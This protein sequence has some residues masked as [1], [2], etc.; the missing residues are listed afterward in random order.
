MVSVVQIGRIFMDKRTAAWTVRGIA[1]H[2]AGA[3]D[4]SGFNGL[5]RYSK[6][7]ETIDP[8]DL[9][10]ITGYI[11]NRQYGGVPTTSDPYAQGNLTL[12]KVVEAGVG[13]NTSRLEG[14]ITSSGNIS[15]VDLLKRGRKILQRIPKLGSY[16]SAQL[17]RLIAFL[18]KGGM[19]KVEFSGNLFLYIGISDRGRGYMRIGSEGRVELKIQQKK[20]ADIAK[21]LG[22][23]TTAETGGRSWQIIFNNMSQHLPKSL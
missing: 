7:P 20:I 18:E 21:E 12:W 9:G 2:L 22:L 17:E 10:I 1:G 4:C 13:I 16:V 6:D 8:L 5:G 11:I 3:V 23:P 19:P 15:L 14:V